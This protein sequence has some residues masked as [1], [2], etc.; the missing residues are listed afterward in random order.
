MG[1]SANSLDERQR[2]SWRVT[3]VILLNQCC[4]D[5]EKFSL[6]D[7]ISQTVSLAFPERDECL[8]LDKLPACVDEPLWSELLRLVPV[9]GVHVARVQGSDH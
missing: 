7:G 5:Q 9:R 3:D 8:M 6:G 4:D 1:Y 2:L